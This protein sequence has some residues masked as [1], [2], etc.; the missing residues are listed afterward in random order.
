MQIKVTG[1]LRLDLS[2]GKDD[3]LAEFEQYLLK[4]KHRTRAA[5]DGE[6]LPGKQGIGDSSQR[7][8][9]QRLDRTLESENKQR[10][11]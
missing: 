4:Y 7:G 9:E 8:S 5:Q 3:V 6:G 11:Y 2:H 10:G 1:H